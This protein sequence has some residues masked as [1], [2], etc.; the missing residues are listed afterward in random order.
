MQTG[1]QARISG[2]VSGMAADVARVVYSLAVGSGDAAAYDIVQK[3]YEQVGRRRL[4]TL[5]F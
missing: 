5:A 2:A 3:L 1:T 4:V